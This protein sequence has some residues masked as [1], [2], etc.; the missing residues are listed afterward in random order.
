MMI[1]DSLRQQQSYEN[2]VKDFKWLH[3]GA[4]GGGDAP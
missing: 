1:S 3:E 2:A 4:A